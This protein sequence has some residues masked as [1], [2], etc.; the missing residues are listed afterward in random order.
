MMELLAPAGYWE[1][2]TAAVQNGADA[3]YLGCG[4]WNARRGAKNFS[5]EE[6][7]EAVKYCHMRGVRV[8]LTLNTLLSDRELPEAEHM[9]RLASRCGVDA[10]IVQDWGALALAREVVP[11]LPLQDR[12]SVV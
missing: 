4:G 11:D 3:V 9:L 2:M 8:Y 10:V 1:A 12:K 5:E 6:M 7:P